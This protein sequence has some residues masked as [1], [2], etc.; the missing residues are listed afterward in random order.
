MF[1]P[2]SWRS[3]R[4]PAID[5]LQTGLVVSSLRI[6]CCF[7]QRPPPGPLHRFPPLRV[8]PLL[9]HS[10]TWHRH[11]PQ[12]DAV[13]V[14]CCS[15]DVVVVVAAASCRTPSAT[16][17]SISFFSVWRRP[18]NSETASNEVES[19]V[20]GNRRRDAIWKGELSAGGRERESERERVREREKEEEEE[21]KKCNR[22]KRENICRDES[23]IF[24]I[25]CLELCRRFLSSKFILV[26]SQLTVL[27]CTN[28]L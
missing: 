22:M 5:V 21:I 28:W 20:E 14:G 11:D 16:V 1:C 27:G 4:L 18:R 24:S 25:L 7:L 3:L 26:I 9:R 17:A 12:T 2:W 13:V 6:C 10:R 15:V 23:K 19:S 8:S